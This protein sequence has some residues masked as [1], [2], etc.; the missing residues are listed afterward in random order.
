[1]GA[2]QS[3]T[4][5]PIIFYNPNVPLQVNILAIKLKF[6]L[7]T[8]YFFGKKKFSQSLVGSLEKKAEQT[9]ERIEAR[10]VESIVR[11]RVAEELENIKQNESELSEK[12]YVELTEKNSEKDNLNAIATN[13]DIETMIER[14][15]RYITV[16]RP[17]EFALFTEYVIDLV[18]K[19][20]LLKLK[21]LKTT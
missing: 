5:E 8:N 21:R 7:V 3:K 11:Q 6:Q 2:S 17:R 10:Q 13:N 18:L 16:K 1:M 4:Q 19:N 14:I 20:F 12:Y 15:S 9:A